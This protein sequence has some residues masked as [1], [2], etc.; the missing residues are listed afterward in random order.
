MS[1]FEQV[2]EIE[3]E[4]PEVDVDALR[5]ALEPADTD[6]RDELF[7]KLNDALE[8]WDREHVQLT[9]TVRRQRAALDKREAEL[10][11]QEA[12]IETLRWQLDL[13]QR[14]EAM[15]QHMHSL[16]RTK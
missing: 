3:T 5:K 1:M 11:A 9:A 4:Q 16:R 14:L 10:D 7:N 8:A 13:E 2:R 12:E 15:R 6:T